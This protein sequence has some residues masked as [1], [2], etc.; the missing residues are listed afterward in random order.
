M[1]IKY[2]KNKNYLIAFNAETLQC[3]RFQSGLKYILPTMLPEN[4]NEDDESFFQ[5][6]INHIKD[7]HMRKYMSAL[8]MKSKFTE[9]LPKK[10]IT[11]SFAPTHNC[12]LK[13]KYCFASGGENYTGD[14][15]D[16]DE[17]VLTKI[18][19]YILIEYAPECEFL[20]VSLVSGGEP[21]LNLDIVE[22]IDGIINQFR[23][24]IKRKIYL[25]T[26]G[27]LYNDAIK[28]KLQLINPQLGI[29]IDGP[30]DY[31]NKNRIFSDGKGTY[32][33][34]NNVIESIKNDSH[35]SLKAKNFVFMSV[36]TEN[37]LDLVKI[38]K[39]HKNLGA[40]SVQMKVVRS[41]GRNDGIQNKNVQLFKDAYRKLSDYLFEQFEANDLSCF[42][43]IMNN[44]DTFGKLL[45]SLLLQ[46]LNNYRCGAGR[47]RFS[48]TAE[49]DIYPCDSFVGKPEFIIGN[50]MEQNVIKNKHIL[51]IFAQLDVGHIESCKECWA[52]YLCTGDCNYNSFMRTGCLNKPDSVMCE[53]YK[54]I[55]E[56]AILLLLNLEDVNKER[57]IKLKRLI[58][59]RENNNLIH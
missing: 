32:N 52:R 19:E 8:L 46:Q 37:N 6:K 21:F 27:T 56:L 34:V 28:K 14:K 4:Y 17:R 26:N 40:S 57:Y 16:M 42:M 1:N 30:E 24:N 25:A 3:L 7:E 10:V 20:Q 35:L 9:G 45:K 47:E 58:E 51:D 43:L 15:K 22:K 55:C 38:L 59:I 50:V 36:I 54:Y 18:I 2:I 33:Q 29:S 44:S 11:I 49:G 39:H 13:C 31:Q 53:F 5:N 23:P 48:F 12:N 41:T